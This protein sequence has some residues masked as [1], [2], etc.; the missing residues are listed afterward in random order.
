MD[1]GVGVCTL[2]PKGADHT[3]VVSS[4]WS[5]M[6][7]VAEDSRTMSHRG[8]GGLGSVGKSATFPLTTHNQKL[9]TK[10]KRQAS[11]L[12]CKSWSYIRDIIPRRF[13]SVR[14]I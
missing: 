8:G 4:V 11:I 7:R 1:A 6:R 12:T 10:R 14:L 13:I 5:V 9:V 2:Q 3:G